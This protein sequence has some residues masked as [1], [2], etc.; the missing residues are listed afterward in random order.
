MRVGETCAWCGLTDPDV[1]SHGQPWVTHESQAHCLVALRLELAYA[2]T[3]MGWVARQL[4]GR[5]WQDVFPRLPEPS[6]PDELPVRFVHAEDFWA[7]VAEMHRD[8]Q[9]VP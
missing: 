8:G 2:H 3:L 1:G 6:V 4:H 7:W 9:K 5:K